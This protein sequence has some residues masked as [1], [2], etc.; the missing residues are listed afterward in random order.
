MLLIS[1]LVNAA[2]D[3]TSS[4]AEEISAAV[5][6]LTGDAKTNGDVYVSAIKKAAAKVPHGSI[7]LALSGLTC[8]NKWCGCPSIYGSQQ[9]HL[10]G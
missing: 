7:T 6:K 8:L 2:A 4:V 9:P 5:A 10:T 1:C 3:A